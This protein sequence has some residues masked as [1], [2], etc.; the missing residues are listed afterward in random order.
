MHEFEYV[1]LDHS[2]IVVYSESPDWEFSAVPA[3][4]AGYSGPGT[5]RTAS[6]RRDSPGPRSLVRETAVP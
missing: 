4:S 6:V 2:L 3:R 5:W 1:N